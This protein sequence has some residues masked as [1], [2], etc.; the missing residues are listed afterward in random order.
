MTLETIVIT[1]FSSILLAIFGA[2]L[3]MF[4]KIDQRVFDL[5]TTVASYLDMMTTKDKEH[6]IKISHIT[7]RVERLEQTKYNKYNNNNKDD[8][9]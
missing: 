4:Q 2:G 6:D 9:N 3:R 7:E 5:N 8:G 1:I